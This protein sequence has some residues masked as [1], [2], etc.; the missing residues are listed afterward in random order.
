MYLTAKR[1]VSEYRD[2]DKELGEKTKTLG[3]PEQ[4]GKVANIVTD[5]A[6]WRKANQIHNWFVQNVQD[7]EDECRPHYVSVT[8]LRELLEACKEVLADHDK[9]E[10]LL[11]VQEGFFFGSY[12][13]DDWY[14]EQIQ[15]TVQ[16][17]ECI[18]SVPESELA[19]WDFE[20]QSSW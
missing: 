7:G 16:Q 11:P 15:D 9:A 12:E 5:A 3:V 4:L 18:L 1:Y 20:Y 17:L 14:F 10:D 13:Y 6:Y 19:N 8:N 2:A